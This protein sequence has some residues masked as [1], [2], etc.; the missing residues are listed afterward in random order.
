LVDQIDAWPD[1]PE[2]TEEMEIRGRW[3]NA[4]DGA[5]K[6]MGDSMLLN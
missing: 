4:G 6:N 1:E 5:V 3:E 2:L